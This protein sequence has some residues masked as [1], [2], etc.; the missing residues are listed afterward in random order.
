[1]IFADCAHV[2]VPEAS[3]L[4]MRYYRSGNVLWV[5]G[6]CL[7]LGIPLLFFIK[8]FTGRL[9]T[10]ATEYGRQWFFSITLYLIVFTVL[11]QLAELPFDI[12]V[13]YFREHAY[14]LSRQ[15]LGQW[16]SDYGKGLGVTMLSA[17][18]FVWIFYLLLKKSPKR[19]WIYGSIV[20]IGV[21][22]ILMFVQPIWIDPLFNTFAPM[23]DKQLEK[24]ILQLAAKAGIHGGRVFEVDKS[25]DTGVLNAYVTGFGSTSRIVLW[26]TTVQ[27]LSKDELLFVM[28]HEMGHY[29]L[30][31]MWWYMLYFSISTFIMFYLIY[32]SA[33]FL[34]HRYQKTW[35]F[36]HL[37][38]IAS[39]PLFMFLIAAFTLISLPIFNAVSRHMEHEADRFGLEITQ[40]NKA[41]AEAFIV[42]QQENLVNPR[43]GMWYQIWRSTHPSLAERIEFANSY[44]PWRQGRELYYQKYFYT[45]SRIESLSAQIHC[46]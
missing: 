44:C 1:M 31:H 33:H 17:I 22:F 25:K 19:W 21:S 46:N 45:T 14:G 29:V 41:A 20:D 42:L 34:V 8:G 12:Y 27:K 18:A 28:G 15:K 26:D 36:K 13:Q 6:Q 10:L 30:H 23:K 2:L 24:E 11:Y 7:G 40:N 39:L 4:A 32:R 5:I 9:S 3:E 16:L 38:N 35:G 43:P 37:Y